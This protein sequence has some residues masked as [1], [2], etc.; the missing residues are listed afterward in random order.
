MQI[1]HIP[2]GMSTVNCSF[3]RTFPTPSQVGHWSP[4]GIVLPCPWQTLHVLAIWKPFSIA[5]VR[6]PVP[7]HA[8][9]VV[10]FDPGLR[11]EEEQGLQSTTGVIVT[12]FFVP[13]QASRK[14]IDICRSMSSPRIF[15]WARPRGPPPAKAPKSSSNRS[16]D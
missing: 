5:K 15:C 7:L 13:L 16:A 4:F 11:P 10:F 6:V 12:F 14:L 3:E 1:S 8:E 9:H 2:I